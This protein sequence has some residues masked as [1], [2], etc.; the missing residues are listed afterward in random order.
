MTT[1]QGAVVVFCDYLIRDDKG[2]CSPYPQFNN[3]ING[4]FYGRCG[5]CE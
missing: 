2:W 4:T 3:K 1:L 5:I